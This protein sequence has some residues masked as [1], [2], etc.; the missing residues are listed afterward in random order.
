M[1]CIIVAKASLLD[2]RYHNY[3]SYVSERF[4]LLVINS[5]LSLPTSQPIF[6]H[7]LFCE[8]L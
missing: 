5:I 3:S 7:M 6:N 1:Q 8:Y 2:N 4:H